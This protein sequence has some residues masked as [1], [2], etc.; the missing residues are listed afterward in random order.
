[1]LFM[2][3]LVTFLMQKFLF[4]HM[5]FLP[6][7]YFGGLFHNWVWRLG[8]LV[9]LSCEIFIGDSDGMGAAM[10]LLFGAMSLAGILGYLCGRIGAKP[11]T[12]E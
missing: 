5:T 9:C 4:N 7:R 10:M 8:T 3:F 12:E 1:M 11:L 2:S 6:F